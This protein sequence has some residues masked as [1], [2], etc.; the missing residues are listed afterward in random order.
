MSL[1]DA[2]WNIFQRIVEGFWTGVFYL[3]G[4]LAVIALLLVIISL[5]RLSKRRALIA[6]EQQQR[7][8]LEIAPDGTALPPLGRGLCDNCGELFDKIYYLPAG[9]KLCPPCYKALHAN[10][11][12]S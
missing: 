1:E 10:D 8:K 4:L 7:K 6:Y 12:R 11:K 9:P 5:I 3:L 2:L